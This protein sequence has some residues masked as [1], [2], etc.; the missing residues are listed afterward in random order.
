[1]TALLAG[2]AA[3]CCAAPA[4]AQ[5]GNLDA[6]KSPA[7]IFAD[8]CSACHRRPQD[9]KRASASFLRSHYSTG[10]EEA[11]AMAGYLAG[12]PSDPRGAA[13]QR[14]QGAAKEAPAAEPP[15]RRQAEPKE[16]KDQAKSG[17]GPAGSSKGRRSA[18]AEPK[19]AAAPPPPPEAKPPEPAVAE[20]PPAPP[21]EPFEE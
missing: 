19:A 9:L 2:L 14:R 21:L 7:Q 11:S 6:G 20:P 18:S 5:Q 12:I 16:Q 17:R 4:D 15:S 1:L 8:T 13:Q 10:S 3:A